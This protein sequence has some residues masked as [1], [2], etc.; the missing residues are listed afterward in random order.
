MSNIDKYK[1]D[2]AT[3]VKLG[4]KM[5]LDLTFRYLS[6]QEKLNEET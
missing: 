2:L 5:E 6:D 4:E 3:L 1:D